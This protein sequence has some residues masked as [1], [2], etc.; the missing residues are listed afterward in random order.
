LALAVLLLCC[1]AVVF[2]DPQCAIYDEGD[3]AVLS[4][5]SGQAISS[6]D[7][8]IFG[9]PSPTGDANCGVSDPDCNLD[10]TQFLSNLCAGRPSCTFQVSNSDFGQDPCPNIP[11]NFF[12]LYECEVAL[13]C[14]DGNGGCD[15]NAQCC[16]A[17]T[18]SSSGS[19]F[20]DCSCNQG[21]DGDGA[22]CYD[23]DECTTIFPCSEG[24][25]CINYPGT[26]GCFPPTPTLAHDH[27]GHVKLHWPQ[28]GDKP[29]LTSLT[30]VITRTS[31]DVVISQLNIPHPASAD[32][33]KFKHLPTGVEYSFQLT[34]LTTDGDLVSGEVLVL[35]IE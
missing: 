17:S 32:S 9:T 8:A 7:N 23:E 10:V 12:A 4:C 13:S 31:D 19:V 16:Q 18:F 2:A 27:Y 6:V 11:K 33:I 28:L 14:D 30:L 3:T 20:P 34:A 1:S 5:P 15:E 24:W 29:R 21:W 35:T 22:V 25:I 26:Y